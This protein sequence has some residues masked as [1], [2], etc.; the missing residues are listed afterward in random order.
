MWRDRTAKNP[1]IGEM[2]LNVPVCYPAKIIYNFV[3]N[4]GRWLAIYSGVHQHHYPVSDF[5][6]EIFHVLLPEFRMID[7]YRF[8]TIW[9]PTPAH[10]RKRCHKTDG[11]HDIS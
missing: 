6:K 4:Y 3:G 10:Q 9:S 11:I 1:D 8:G 2:L 5:I 7:M